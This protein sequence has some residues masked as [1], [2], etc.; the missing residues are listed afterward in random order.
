MRFVNDQAGAPISYQLFVARTGM[1]IAPGANGTVGKGYVLLNST[2]SV[3]AN[4]T[5][6]FG[7]NAGGSGFY[8][9]AALIN[10][11][12]SGAGTIGAGIWNV[13]TAPLSL[14]D[15]SFVGWKSAGCTGLNLATAV[16]AAT[17]SS[18][19]ASQATEYDSRDHILNRVVAVTANV[20]S[21]FQAAGST[22]D[23]SS[24][25]TAW[26]AP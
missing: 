9:Q 17:T 6:Y 7:R 26:G 19:I 21:G 5:A 4:V 13:G 25:A 2:V 12:F 22:W 15:S 20:P 16:T 10:V 1:T 23:V 3:D 24:L 8:D 11:T 18:T 14:G